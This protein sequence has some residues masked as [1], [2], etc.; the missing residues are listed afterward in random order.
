MKK[1]PSRPPGAFGELMDWIDA[2]APFAPKAFG[3]TPYVRIEDYVEG[4]T[5]VVRAE[6]PGIDPDKDVT[7]TVDEDRLTISGERREEEKDKN[8]R[9]LHYGSFTRTVTLPPGARADAITASYT[10]GVL[11]VR[12]PTEAKTS[13]AVTVPVTRPENGTS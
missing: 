13:S 6:M 11:E 1:D 7:V 3:L 5:Y 12:V 10:D 2:G 8:R 9:E 4:D